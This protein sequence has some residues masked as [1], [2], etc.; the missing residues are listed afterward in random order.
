MFSYFAKI[1]KSLEYQSVLKVYYL[2][3]NRQKRAKS[4]N[5]RKSQS[6]DNQLYTF[7]LF[8]LLYPLC[9]GSGYYKPLANQ[10][11]Y[12]GLFPVCTKNREV[13][14]LPNVHYSENEHNCLILSL[15]IGAARFRSA[16]LITFL[17]VRL[18]C[19]LY[20]SSCLP[21]M[22]TNALVKEITFTLIYYLNSE[23]G[24]TTKPLVKLRCDDTTL[25]SENERCQA[26][27]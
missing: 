25:F 1:L 22:K 13:S 8:L 15:S 18:S 2:T 12:K 16:P 6:V 3:K 9:T 24:Q 20:Q 7:S 21:Y 11:I 27:S 19:S 23:A 26:W 4:T 10:R 5:I 17:I 14:S